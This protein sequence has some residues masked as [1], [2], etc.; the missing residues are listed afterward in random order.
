MTTVLTSAF[1]Y[2]PFARR[3]GIYLR[4]ATI[5]SKTR[6]L[7]QQIRDIPNWVSHY[8][9]SSNRQPERPKASPNHCINIHSLRDIWFRAGV[10][11]LTENGDIVSTAR[12]R[13]ISRRDIQK[14]RVSMISYCRCGLPSFLSVYLVCLS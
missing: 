11:K 1:P 10:S 9:A 4:L 7:R 14:Q 3:R 6:A 13:F 2:P 5:L 8:T 12:P